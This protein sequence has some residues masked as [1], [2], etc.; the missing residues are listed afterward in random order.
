MWISPRTTWTT[1]YL[2][3]VPAMTLKRY[4]S[5]KK[6]TSLVNGTINE[7]SEPSSLSSLEKEV[8]D[9]VDNGACGAAAA[10]VFDDDDEEDVTVATTTFSNSPPGVFSPTFCRRKRQESTSLVSHPIKDDNLQD[11]HEHKLTSGADSL[12]V[13]YNLYSMVVSFFLQ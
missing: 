12:V 2:A 8:E 13:K 5:I 10:A 9:E 11:F 1:D 7:I 4:Q 3:A 6:R